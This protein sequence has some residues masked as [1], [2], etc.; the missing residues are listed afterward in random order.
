M[1]DL[2]TYG[3]LAQWLAQDPESMTVERIQSLPQAI[4]IAV[5]VAT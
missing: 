3:E 4:D 5:G 2:L 1:H